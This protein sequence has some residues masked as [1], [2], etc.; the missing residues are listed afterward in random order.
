MTL[1]PLPSLSP[2]IPDPD[3]IPQGDVGNT[4]VQ[5]S[6]DR[7]F[8][9]SEDGLTLQS[10]HD[11]CMSLCKQ[12]WIRA[13]RMKKRGRVFKQG[14][15]VVKSSKGEPSAYKDPAFKDFK[16]DFEDL[17]DDAIDYQRTKEVKG[18][19]STALH[20]GTEKEKVSTDTKKVSTDRAREGTDTQKVSTDTQKVSTDRAKEGTDT[21]KVSTDSTKLSTD[22]V[23]EGTDEPGD[24]QTPTPT[25]PTSTTATFR[26]DETISKVLLN[27]SQVRAVSREKEKGVE[28]RDVED[29]ERPRPTSTRSILNL[30]PLPKIDPKDKRKKRIEEDDESGTESDE[31]TTAEKKFKQLT[32]NEELARKIQEDW[33]EE[34]ENK[35]LANEEAKNAALIHDFDDINARIEVDGLLALRLQEEERE[36]FTIE[37]R[38]KFLHDTIEAQRK[39]LAQ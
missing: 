8:S 14:R 27:M 21:Q 34:E 10:L 9:G 29:T 15:K 26:D 38:A 22:K 3:S 16:D 35:R 20:Q 39:F 28:L 11:L 12:A 17:L 31:I 36:Q 30:K 13:T 4:G 25:T 18:E 7:S 24:V 1:L 32:A 6:N 33:E 23:E 5:S 19:D 37:E 2:P